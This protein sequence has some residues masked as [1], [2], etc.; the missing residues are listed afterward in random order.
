[1]TDF[2]GRAAPDRLLPLLWRHH[3]PPTA[4]RGRPPRLSVDA[5]VDAAIAR[6][7]ADGLAAASMA[8]IGTDLGVGTMTIY[9]YVPSRDQLVDLMVDEVLARRALPGPGEPRPAGW[10]DQVRLYA[11]RTGA[12]YAEHPWLAQVSQVRPPIGPGMLAEREYVL[13]VVAGLDLPVDRVNTAAVMIQ[14]FVTASARS[15]AE[16]ELIRRAT[17]EDNDAWWMRRQDLWETWF[18]V[19]RHPAMT[20]LW[21]AGGFDRSPDEQVLDA[22]R[23]GLELIL[24]GLRPSFGP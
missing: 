21:N 4:A 10:R 18:D 8:R 3:A 19:D 15:L 6:A 1:M 22:Y 20:A 16:I 24:D 14:A 5:V 7:D 11:D 23:Y 2:S 9:T 17:G 12:M 13:S